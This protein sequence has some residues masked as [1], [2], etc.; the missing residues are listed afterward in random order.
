MSLVDGQPRPRIGLGTKLFYGSGSLAFGAKDNGIQTFLLLFYSQVLGLPQ[1][2]VALTIAGVMLVD[3]F[4]DPI[5]GQTSDNL[6]SRWGRRHPYMYFAAI[7]VAISYFLLWS[8][9]AGLSPVMLTVYMAVVLILCR[10]FISAYEVPSS[11]LVAELTDD[12]HQRTTLL[13]FRFVFGWAGGLAMYLLAYQVFLRPTAAQPN[14]ILN[15]EGYAHYGLTA[16]VLMVV[17]IVVSSLGTHRLIPWLRK[18]PTEQRTMGALMKNMLAT[19]RHRSFLMM[20]GV[21]L[22]AAMGQGI[23]FTLNAYI[24]N[25]FWQ[26]SGNQ[27]SI[28]IVQ[29]VFAAFAS[30]VVA[31]VV[32]RWLGKKLAAMVLMGAS[33]LL[34]ALP[35]ILR[36]L[37]LFPANGSWTLV[38]TLLVMGCITAPMGIAASILVSSMIADVVEDSELR[39]GERSE[40]LFFS[41]AA[42]VN[43]SV[44]G[45]GVLGAGAILW[46]IQFPIGAAPHHVPESTL[47]NLA[48]LYIPVTIVL[49]A[50][51]IGFM[52]RYQISKDTHEDNLRK[53]AEE[54]LAA[55]E[56]LREKG[57]GIEPPS[58]TG[59]PR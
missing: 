30:T 12:Y 9:P 29:A 41:A 14:G 56:A 10:T 58:S 18:P 52:S 50:I 13:S 32:S 45:L 34:G 27:I 54:E 42:F 4:A 20:L 36:L 43:K 35:M 40:G 26:L 22:F 46:L 15:A 16:A 7:P 6:H 57:G 1:I 53:L 25:Y 17:S 44:S 39:T 8:P 2:W 33:V 47:N 28:L 37:D 31:A 11:A 21:G 48:L 38:W 3:A 24:V 23:G 49:Y 19:L 5:I 59:F 51:A 55:E